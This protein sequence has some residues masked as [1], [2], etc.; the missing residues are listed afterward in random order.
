MMEWVLR[1]QPNADPYVDEII[2]GSMGVAEEEVLAN[3]ERDIREVLQILEEYE[4]VA[5]WKKNQIVNE[6]GVIL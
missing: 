3:H 5:D 2:I 6:G 4:L 1:D